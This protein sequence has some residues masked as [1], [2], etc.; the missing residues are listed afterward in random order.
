MCP[1][2]ARQTLNGV[3]RLAQPSALT[4]FGATALG[5]AASSAGCFCRWFGYQVLRAADLRFDKL[6]DGQ[7]FGGQY[8]AYN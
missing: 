6:R 7:S 5:G 3:V 2:G 8:G 1:V 4:G